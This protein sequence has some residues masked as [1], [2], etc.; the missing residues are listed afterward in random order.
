SGR[1]AHHLGLVTRR[2]DDVGRLVR[3]FLVEDGRVPEEVARALADDLALLDQRHAGKRRLQPFDIVAG[4]RLGRRAGV[5]FG[6]H[7]RLTPTSEVFD[8][9]ASGAKQSRMERSASPWNASLAMTK[10]S[11]LALQR[12]LMPAAQ[13]QMRD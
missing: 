6:T 5:W 8:V 3:Q 9:I 2:G 12:A 4:G 13:Q 10:G 7:V 1:D 11:V